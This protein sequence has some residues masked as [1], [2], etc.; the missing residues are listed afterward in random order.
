MDFL[1]TVQQ[2]ISTAVAGDL[3]AFA[4]S[5]DWLALLAV[6]P[7]GIVFGAVHALT[8]GHSKT[9]LATYVAGSS[10]AALRSVGLAI[11]LALT[12]VFFAVAIAML[13]LPLVS[14]AL[15]SVGRAP[16][17]E[18]LSRGLLAAIGVWMIVRSLGWRFRIRAEGPI[19]AV[20]AGLIPC[21][22]TLFAM[23]FAIGRGVPEAGLVFAMAMMLGVAT[24]LAA[25]ALFAAFARNR[26]V[27]FFA[28]NHAQ[29]TLTSRALEG[30]AGACL[31]L[32][33]IYELLF[34]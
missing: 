20:I 10:I 27:G 33:G 24:T 29:L 13:A 12:H 14:R 3:N 32:I 25:V 7:I 23:I 30:A 9:V 18:D 8:P 16:L 31:I 22:L 28:H 34:R 5:R 11:I 26:L 4:Q 6:L 1:F 21:P 19:V 2:S 17:M 15:D